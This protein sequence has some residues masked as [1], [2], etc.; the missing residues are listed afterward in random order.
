MRVTES[1]LFGQL[2]QNVDSS[3]SNF[4]SLQQELAT[5]KRINQPSDDPSGTNQALTI[6]SILVD[7]NQYKTDANSASS[8][9]SFSD[10]Q[11]NSVTALVQQARTIAV[12]AA[13]TATQTP[14]SLAAMGTQIQSIIDQ[15]T[16]IANSEYAGRHIFSGQQT[17]T[18]PYTVGDATHTY[19]GDT[20]ALNA[21]IGKSTTVQIN[22]PGSQVF[23]AQ[24]AA[25]EQLKT[26]IAAGNGAAIST[27]DLPA[28]DNG[29]NVINQTRGT[30]GAR[31]NEVSDTVSRLGTTQINY[32]NQLSSIEDVDIASVYAQMQIAQNT[33]QA[34]LVTTQKAL[35][36]SLANYLQ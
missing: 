21:T 23:Q 22:T 14:T 32:Q 15:V 36:Y 18:D 16:N 19:H 34:S 25:L 27:N 33:Y 31:L 11:L 10:S 8:F 30:I 20:G 6:R 13:N 12:G 17:K 1:L 5:G 24:F 7:I 3:S 26:D 35:Q 9:L 4:Q 2:T 29:L 28:I